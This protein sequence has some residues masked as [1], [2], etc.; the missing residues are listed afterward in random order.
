MTQVPDFKR[1]NTEDFKSEERQLI[2]KLANILNL[3]NEQLVTLLTKNIDFTNLKQE[4][5]DIEIIVN[6]NGIPTVSSGFKNNLNSKIK[7]VICIRSQNLTNTSSYPTGAIIMAF[8]EV[9]NSV[10]IKHVTGLQANNKYKLT[11]ITIG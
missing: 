11:I 6:S 7:G 1:I 4:L 9:N 3:F 5:K 2:E 10:L 8:E